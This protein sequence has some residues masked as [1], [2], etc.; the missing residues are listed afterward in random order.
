MNAIISDNGSLLIGN[1]ITE[2]IA[3]RKL[4]GYAKAVE[5]RIRVSHPLLGEVTAKVH[6]EYKIPEVRYFPLNEENVIDL[7]THSGFLHRWCEWH[8]EHNSPRPWC[9]EFVQKWICFHQKQ[10]PELILPEAVE[11][12]ILV[13][14][15]PTISGGE[16]VNFWA[17]ARLP[18]TSL[19]W[20]NEDFPHANGSKNCVVA[21]TEDGQEIDLCVY[22]SPDQETYRGY[23]QN[24]T[25]IYFGDT[26]RV[27]RPPRQL[28]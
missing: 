15:Y 8:D 18:R 20:Y 25:G 5:N 11:I 10:I 24:Q 6:F 19:P 7:K 28:R 4:A 13:E 27:A 21:F 14:R 2:V 23:P 26:I 16:L 9:V 12:R 1:G 17:A 22:F 3:D